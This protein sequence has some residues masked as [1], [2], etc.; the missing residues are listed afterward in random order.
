MNQ[1]RCVFYQVNWITGLPE[2]YHKIADVSQG[3]YCIRAGVYNS[4]RDHQPVEKCV[5]LRKAETGI[6]LGK[7]IALYGPLSLTVGLVL[8]VVLAYLYLKPKHVKPPNVLQSI[9]AQKPNVLESSSPDTCTM[10]I[11]SHQTLGCKGDEVLKHEDKNNTLLATGHKNSSTSTRETNSLHSKV[12]IRLA[13]DVD[14]DVDD[15]EDDGAADG[16]HTG[17]THNSA[18]Y[19][20]APDCSDED[21]TGLE[22]ENGVSSVYMERVM[23]GA[24]WQVHVQQSN[25]SRDGLTIGTCT[26]VPIEEDTRHQR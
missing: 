8:I 25:S 22:G 2:G 4:Q 10:M 13:S 20:L 16:H 23:V 17:A 3:R 11:V 1:H 18:G 9:A 5:V 26:A 24:Q 15:E 19:E 12:S 6:S 14:E 21:D 7:M